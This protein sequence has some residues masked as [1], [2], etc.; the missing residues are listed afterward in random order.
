MDAMNTGFV[1]VAN[2]CDGGMNGGNFMWAIFFLALLEGRGGFGWGGNNGGW[3]SATETLSNEFLYTNLNNT[4]GQGFTQNANGQIQTQKDIW[5]T[6]S[7]LQMQL[8]NNNFNMQNCCCETQ[9]A[10][11]S[12]KYENAQNTCAINANTTEQVRMIYDKLCQMEGNAK[13][14]RI[15]D[16]QIQLQSA[17][18]QLSNLAQTANIINQVRPTP[19][20]AFTVGNPYATVNCGFGGSCCNYAG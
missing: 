13:D 17:Q 12:V 1:P 5:Q 4:I 7:D 2:V 8:A 9:R 15:N 3:N 10:I 18:N 16:L 19:I 6:H 14:Q 20:P 11:D